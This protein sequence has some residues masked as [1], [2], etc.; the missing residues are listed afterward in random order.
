MACKKIVCLGGGSAYFARALPDLVVAEGL[1]GS[2]IVLYDID[3][4]KAEIMASHGRRM[5]EEA[6]LGMRVRAC[7]DVAEAVDGADFAISAIGGSGAGAGSVYGSPAHAADI[8]IPARYGIYQIIGDTG[9]P[10]GMM[11]GLRSV[12]IYLDICR[13]MEKR[14]PDVVLLNHSNPMAVLC[15]AMLKYT[16]LRNVIGICHGVQIGLRHAADV[17]E[18]D[19]HELDAV[20]IGTNHYYWFTRL[21][22]RG[23]DVYPELISRTAERAP[24][25]GSEMASRLSRIYG[26]QL[27]FPDDTH[28]IEFYPFL[29]QVGGPKDIPYGMQPLLGEADY[30]MF[31]PEAGEGAGPPDRAAQLETFQELLAGAELPQ[32]PSDA[33]TGEGLGSLV[34]AIALG[35]R[36][37]HIVNIP[38]RGC[39]PNL[40]DYAVLEVE[41]VTDSVGVRGLYA[42]EAPLALAGLLQKRIAWQEMVVEA[43]IKG[44]PNLAVQAALLDEMAIPPEKAE[45][46]V[47][48]LLAASSGHLPQFK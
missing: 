14:C 1:S 34:E 44:D 15:R 30:S 8:L 25:P 16:G 6:G 43:A 28:I 41:G 18:V 47:G 46:M 32:E 36:K 24:K 31:K 12:P 23:R 11:M 10:A 9:G 13:E 2:E 29:A 39:V 7:G 21:R 3:H 22:C 37:V 48:E 5:A 40:P 4:E 26:F 19:P 35:R 20:W 42:G 33:V 38:N 17:L 45:A 27:L